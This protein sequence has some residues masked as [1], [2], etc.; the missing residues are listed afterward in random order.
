MPPKKNQKQKKAQRPPAKKRSRQQRTVTG[1][2]PGPMAQS[3]GASAN[4]SVGTLRV[5]NK[6]YWGLLTVADPAA[7]T[8]LG[9]APGKSG[10][11]V[12]DG[13]G[14]VY[15]N[16]RVHRARVYLVGTSPTTST[17]VV[18]S[19][20]DYEPA[21]VAKTQDLVLRTVPNVTVPGYRNAVLT[22]NKT[23]MMR[24]NWFVSNVSGYT[25]DSTAFLLVSWVAG[26]KG[27][28]MLVYCD[29]DVEFR[30]PSKSGA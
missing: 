10:M 28:S 9:F 2:V 30:N 14:S 7:I 5:R 4:S 26:A 21:V 17:T 29:Y 24:R 1:M 20:I 13:L 19:C 22:A 16:Y 18:N 6:E 3:V 8:T 23:S 15:D 11:T 12:L 27:E 25:E